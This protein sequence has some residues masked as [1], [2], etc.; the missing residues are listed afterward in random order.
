MKRFALFLCLMLCGLTPQSGAEKMPESRIIYLYVPACQSCAKVAA[1]LNSLGDD[2]IVRTDSGGRTR[3]RLVI[4]RVDISRD[5]AYAEA[6][7]DQH[8][9]PPAAQIVPSV[10]FDGQYLAGEDCIL[11]ELPNALARG[12]ALV[13]STAA[14]IPKADLSAA[15]RLSLGASMGAGLIAG[16]NPC[17]LSMMILL[18]GNLLH[19][20]RRSAFLASIFLL[21]KLVTYFMIGLLLLNVLQAWNPVSLTFSLKFV[22]SVLAGFLIVLNLQ[23]AWRAARGDYGMV[24]NQLPSGSR[25]RLQALIKRM[26]SSPRLLL[27]MVI[28]GVLVSLGEFLCAGQLYLATLL[29]AINNG[30]RSAQQ[31]LMLAVYCLAFITPSALLTLVILRLQHTLQASDFIRRR[32]P[33]IKLL[34]ALVLALAIFYAWRV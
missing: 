33:L 10:Y 32:M 11:E 5:P 2:V 25:Q 27:A 3:S 16:F 20:G 1:L 24:R 17:A 8:S 29:A 7:F 12:E 19:L 14:I 21:C 15:N 13:E 23:D 34:T 22:L 6:L 26:T 30:A 18:L 9:T 4:E 28:L 31:L